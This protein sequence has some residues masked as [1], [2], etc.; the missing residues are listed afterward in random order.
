ME[1]GAGNKIA[2]KKLKIGITGGIGSGKS[3]VCRLFE[4][5]GIPVYYADDRAKSIMVDKMEVVEQIIDLLGPAAYF[6]DGSL[7]RQFIAG[8]VFKDSEKLQKLNKIVH[9]AVRTDGIEW[10]HS[11]TD[12]PYTLKE[13]ALLIESGNYQSMDKIIVVSAPKEMRI[14][15]VM[16]RDQVEKAAVLARMEKQLPEKEKIKKADFVI[17]NDL[18]RPLIQQVWKIHQSLLASISREKKV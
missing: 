10:H 13:A 6:P 17:T 14:Q 5:L 4:V 8:I 15:R 1:Q 7:N 9:P 12:V 18:T 2:E 11:Q 16:T 3:T